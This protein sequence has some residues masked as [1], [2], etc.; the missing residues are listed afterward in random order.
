[1]AVALSYFKKETIMADA[2]QNKGFTIP[3][4]TSEKEQSTNTPTSSPV[5]Q[6]K[7]I[8]LSPGVETDI[9]QPRDYAIAGGVLLVLLIAFFFAKNAYANHLAGK[10]VPTGAA[11]AAGWWLFI[12]MTG[13]AT[14]AVLSV[15]SPVKF[16]TPIFMGPLLLVSL[17]ALVLMFVVGRRK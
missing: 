16:L 6:A 11:N 17:V 2:T 5:S 3:S 10:R 9:P 12:F 7:E 13:L 8:V 4:P 1:M 14:A 15:L